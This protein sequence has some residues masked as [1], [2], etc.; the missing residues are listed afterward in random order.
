MSDL[1]KLVRDKIPEIIREDGKIPK[2]RRLS[3]DKIEKWLRRKVLEE[4]EEFAEEGEV[5]ELADLYAILQEYMGSEDISFSKLKDFE[6][7]K[8]EERGGLKQRI[9]LE[10]VEDE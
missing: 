2:T 5:E 10:D 1:P 4:A 7:E 3:E 6:E 8:A 9:V